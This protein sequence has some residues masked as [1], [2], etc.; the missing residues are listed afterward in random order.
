MTILY[1]QKD[2][3]HYQKE[4][5]DIRRSV[6][7]PVSG[8]QTGKKSKGFFAQGACLYVPFP[9]PECKV[10][11]QVLSAVCRKQRDLLLKNEGKGDLIRVQKER[12]CPEN[13]RR[14]LVGFLYAACGRHFYIENFRRKER[15]WMREKR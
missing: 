3:R 5:E 6:V 15:R 9:C 10:T 2:R 13:G 14:Q 8:F 1:I 4:K 7:V 12:E 11:G